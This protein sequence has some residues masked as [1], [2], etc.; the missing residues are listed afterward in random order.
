MV[1]DTLFAFLHIATPRTTCFALHGK[2]KLN[3]INN[4]RKTGERA[5]RIKKIIKSLF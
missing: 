4:K 3:R 2:R 1:S 5:K